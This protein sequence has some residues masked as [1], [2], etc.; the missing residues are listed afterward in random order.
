MQKGLHCPA[1][2]VPAHY[3]V[4][5]P[6]RRYRILDHGGH[7]PRHRA[8]GRHHVADIPGNEEFPRT[9][10]RDCLHIHPGIGAGNDQGVRRLRCRR[11]SL[12]FLRTLGVDLNL[13]FPRPCLQLLQNTLIAHS[14]RFSPPCTC[15][16][17]S[18]QYQSSPPSL[19]QNQT[20][21]EFDSAIT[22]DS[23]PRSL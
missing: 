1:I 13:K 19:R 16:R 15:F 22:T 17:V 10:A 18:T 20:G 5:Y 6:E 3:C 12:V 21:T 8:V 7:A 2:R 23:V 11:G 14:S 4:P 9:R